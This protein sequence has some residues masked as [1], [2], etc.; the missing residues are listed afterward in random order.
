MLKKSDLINFED[1]I[2]K[3]YESGKIKAPIHLSGNNEDQLIKIFKKVKKNDWV[4]STWRNHYHALLKGIPK[5]WLKKE[6][7]EG[8]SMGINNIKYKFYSS[9][10]VGGIL[11]IALGVG[12]SIQ[13]KKKKNKVWVFIGDMTFE[14]GI[15]HECYKYS[16]NFKLP[17]KF[18]V[19]DNNMS[20]NSPTDKVWFKKSLVPKGVIKYNYKRKYPHHG[21]GG[22]VLF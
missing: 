22:W 13:L 2:K 17:I 19:E 7:I 10:I 9:A 3:V 6:I 11:P 8:R 14:T 18:V 20:T 5:E 16:K 12:K 15:F 4:F 21:T 1:D